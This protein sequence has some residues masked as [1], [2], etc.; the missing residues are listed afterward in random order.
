MSEAGLK[1]RCLAANETECRGCQGGGKISWCDPQTVVSLGRAKQ[2]PH[3]RVMG[4]NIR[5]LKS[6]STH[7]R[8]LQ[9]GDGEC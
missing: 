1:N 6:D 5:F 8:F 9:T 4:R 7:P 2:I 3:L